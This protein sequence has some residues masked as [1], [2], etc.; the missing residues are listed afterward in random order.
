MAHYKSMEAPVGWSPKKGEWIIGKY[1]KEQV[2][3]KFERTARVRT[4]AVLAF[5]MTSSGKRIGLIEIKPME[6]R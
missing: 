2:R 3:A 4:G 5:C 6:V 1:R